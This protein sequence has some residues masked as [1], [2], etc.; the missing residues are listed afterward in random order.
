MPIEICGTTRELEYGRDKRNNNNNKSDINKCWAYFLWQVL[1]TSSCF[2][3]PW[4][5]RNHK[6]AEWPT[7]LR[8]QF[9]VWARVGVRVRVRVKYAKQTAWRE[10]AIIV[11]DSCLRG[12][13]PL[14][15]LSRILQCLPF[16]PRH[17][18]TRRSPQSREATRQRPRAKCHWHFNVLMKMRAKSKSTRWKK[19]NK[20]C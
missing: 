4:R 10:V 17:S 1:L 19:T 7:G 14:A 2:L 16:R 9:R 3:W 13:L 20:I 6:A 12:R 8:V 15:F 5:Q 11:S 18:A